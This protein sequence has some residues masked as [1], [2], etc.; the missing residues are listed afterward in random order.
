VR[1]HWIGACAKCPG[2]K[3]DDAAVGIDAAIACIRADLERFRAWW[4]ERGLGATRPTLAEW[5]A[6]AFEFA[7]ANGASAT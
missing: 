4:I 7:R 6:E 2:E 5:R 1:D 3:A